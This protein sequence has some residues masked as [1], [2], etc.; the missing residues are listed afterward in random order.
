MLYMQRK[1]VKANDYRNDLKSLTK[2][3]RLIYVLAQFP[4]ATSEMELDY[5]HL[6]LTVRV[7]S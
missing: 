1:S 2:Y 6:K 4:F 7:A 5:Y 3:L